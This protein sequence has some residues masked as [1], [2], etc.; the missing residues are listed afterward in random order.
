[1]YIYS[2]LF[3]LYWC[4]DYCH[5]TTTQLQLVAVLVSFSLLIPFFILLSIYN[6]VYLFFTSFS[7]SPP[8]CSLPSLYSNHDSSP[9]FPK[10]TNATSNTQ[11]HSPSISLHCIEGFQRL[12][13][14]LV[15]THAT[16]LRA[17]RTDLTRHCRTHCPTHLGAL[18]SLELS[19]RH[20]YT[21]TVSTSSPA[22]ITQ[23]PATTNY[24]PALQFI[25]QV[26]SSRQSSISFFFFQSKV[27]FLGSRN[28]SVVK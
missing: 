26:L 6:F 25:L 1:M 28:M 8:P 12:K 15:Q 9:S 22:I 2:Y 11:S 3:C 4:K 21:S 14:Q 27:T 20:T 17:H 5:R 19:H 24:I 23:H 10:A 13:N 18:R 16:T 7:S